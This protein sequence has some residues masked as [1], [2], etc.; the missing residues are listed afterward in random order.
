MSSYSEDSDSENSDSDSNTTNHEQCG[1]C[2]ESRSLI[3]GEWKT[4]CICNIEAARCCN[5]FW[6]KCIKCRKELKEIIKKEPWRWNYGK[7]CCDNC[8]PDGIQFIC[9]DHGGMKLDE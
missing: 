9:E 8:N 3:C 5:Q 4:C 6:K 2:Y 7:V 1:Q